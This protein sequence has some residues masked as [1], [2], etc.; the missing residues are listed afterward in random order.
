MTNKLSD[1]QNIQNAKIERHARKS[2]NLNRG[3]LYPKSIN[4]GGWI[5]PPFIFYSEKSI[6]LSA[7]FH[8]ILI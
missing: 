5:I 7:I 6:E 1:N 4:N 2:A 3:I 8:V